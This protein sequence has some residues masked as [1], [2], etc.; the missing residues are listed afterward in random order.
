MISSLHY[1]GLISYFDHILAYMPVEI[2]ILFVYWMDFCD[3]CRLNSQSGLTLGSDGIL[4]PLTSDLPEEGLD[5]SE[6]SPAEES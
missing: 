1:L 2:C 5:M 3:P 4:G 6:V